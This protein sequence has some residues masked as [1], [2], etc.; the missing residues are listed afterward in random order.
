MASDIIKDDLGHGVPEST[1]HITLSPEIW[2]LIFA[3]LDNLKDLCNVSLTSRT[4]QM[5]AMPHLYKSVPLTPRDVSPLNRDPGAELQHY[6]IL[7]T[8]LEKPENERLRIV[9]RELEFGG[10]DRSGSFS[11]SELEPKEKRLLSLVDKLP[12]LRRIKFGCSVSQETLQRLVG[13]KNISLYLLDEDGKRQFQGELPNVLTLKAAVKG[14]WLRNVL[15][16][17]VLG[18]QKL[19]FSCPNLKSFS[20][21]VR[22]PYG[23]CMMLPPRFPILHHFQFSGNERF[24]AL[25]ELSLSGYEFWDEERI[26]RRFWRERFQWAKLRTLKLGPLQQSEFLEGAKGYATSLQNLTVDIYTD[27]DEYTDCPPLEEFLASF[28]SL[29]SLTVRGYIVPLKPISHHPALKH[30]ILHSFGELELGNT[31]HSYSVSDLQE[32]DS[33]C[34]HLETLELDL[35]RDGEWPEEWLKAI[36]TGFKRLR[37]LTFHLELIP[38]DSE[39]MDGGGFSPLIEPILTTDSAR[40]IGKRFFKWRGE[41]SNLN[42]IILKTGEPLRRYQQ[43]EPPEYRFERSQA[44]TL[45]VFRP[46]IPGD[47][48]EVVKYAKHWREWW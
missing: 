34:P 9:V 14:P 16:Q 31:R 3:E 23:G 24:P 35:N 41:Q 47:I 5:M 28:S 15:N 4:W 30:L 17:D 18:V 2:H 29:E 10:C 11:G 21:E 37:R 39:Q 20:L 6:N 36:A 8:M 26:H 13:R 46:R 33:I 45:E 44:A 7:S 27:G 43:R 48:P 1:F 22:T 40:E 32:L 19:L 38:K 25:E 42:T 12:N